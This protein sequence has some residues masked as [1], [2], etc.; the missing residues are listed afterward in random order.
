MARTS[1]TACSAS[2]LK[3]GITYTAIT[4]HA[5]IR[6]M[7][8][9]S[10]KD[11]VVFSIYAQLSCGVIKDWNGGVRVGRVLRRAAMRRGVGNMEQEGVVISGQYVAQSESDDWNTH[12]TSGV[13]YITDRLMKRKPR[14]VFNFVS[15]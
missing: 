1:R 14:N 10:A 11:I 4:A 7:D 13:T 15:S 3:F 9:S 5:P 6:E 12:S 2:T 8:D